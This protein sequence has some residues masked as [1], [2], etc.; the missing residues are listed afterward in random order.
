MRIAEKTI[1]IVFHEL[2]TYFNYFLNLSDK[3]KK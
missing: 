2:V 3:Y 1:I